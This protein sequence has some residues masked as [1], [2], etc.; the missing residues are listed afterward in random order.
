MTLKIERLR[1][2]CIRRY[3]ALPQGKG[4]IFVRI[5]RSIAPG[6]KGRRSSHYL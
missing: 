2:N 4:G 1:A 3:A 5:Y 6:A